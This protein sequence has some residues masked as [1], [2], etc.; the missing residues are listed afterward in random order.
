MVQLCIYIGIEI[1]S[2]FYRYY[3]HMKSPTVSVTPWEHN[4][5]QVAIHSSFLVT[6]KYIVACKILT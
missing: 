5:G 1:P 4:N 3:V 2:H 6:C